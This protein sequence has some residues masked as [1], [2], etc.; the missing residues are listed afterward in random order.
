VGIK[1]KSHKTKAAIHNIGTFRSPQRCT[2]VHELYFG[3]TV[4]TYEASVALP[5]GCNLTVETLK[6][7]DGRTV[8]KQ[9]FVFEPKTLN[10]SEPGEPVLVYADMALA[11]FNPDPAATYRLTA[12]P[13]N[14]PV[15]PSLGLLSRL[16]SVKIGLLYGA[17]GNGLIDVSLDNIRY[18]SDLPCP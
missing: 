15:L 17:I 9:H 10:V 1:P 12:V 11:T 3:C 6:A 7:G 8:A 5:F 4:G 14:R 16:L 18:I 2:K 13:L